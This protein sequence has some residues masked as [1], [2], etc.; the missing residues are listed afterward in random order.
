MCGSDGMDQTVYDVPFNYEPVID[1]SKLK[2][3]YLKSDFD[4]PYDFHLQDSVTLTKLKELGA[5]LFSIELPALP[6][7]PLLELFYQ[8]K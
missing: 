5:E 7:Q 3:G 1:F 8:Q 6:I 2:I 4:K